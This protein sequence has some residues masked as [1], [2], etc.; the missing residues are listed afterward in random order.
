MLQA[1]IMEAGCSGRRRGAR[2]GSGGTLYAKTK[3][4]DGGGTLNGRKAGQTGAEREGARRSV[5]LCLK[6]L[7]SVLDTKHIRAFIV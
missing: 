7:M 1:A 2:G 3:Q 4:T 6:G 5:G